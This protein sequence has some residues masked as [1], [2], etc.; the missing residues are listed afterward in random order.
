GK[1]G[2]SAADNNHRRVMVGVAARSRDPVTPVLGAEVARRIG[3]GAPPEFVFMA[4][5][6]VQVRIE[7]PGAQLPVWVGREP[8]NA[9][10]RSGGSLEL[11]QGLDR[12]AACTGDPAWRR[13]L[14]GDVKILRLR[15][16]KRLAQSRFDRG[17]ARQ[18]LDGP[19]EGEHV[20]P[21]A[22]LEKKR[23]RG[24]GVG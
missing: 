12:V 24:L 22:V 2:L 15:A 10:A 17:A 19:R 20:T 8:Q 11:E 7:R 14:C 6:L 5:Q 9:V 3:F 16:G 4:S 18:G 23:R 21:Q 1:P 13:A